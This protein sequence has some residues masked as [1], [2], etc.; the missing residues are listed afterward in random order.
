MDG[1]ASTRQKL[2]LSCLYGVQYFSSSASKARILDV[3]WE[4]LMKDVYSLKSLRN[5]AV[6]GDPW[7]LPE[8]VNDSEQSRVLSKF[9]TGNSGIGNRA[10]ILGLQQAQKYCLLCQEGDSKHWL[11][12]YHVVFKCRRL[13]HVQVEL[14]LQA[15]KIKNRNK[16]SILRRFLGGDG[17]SHVVLM[18]G[19]SRLERL[20][21]AYFTEMRTI[22]INGRKNCY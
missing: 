15:Y 13:R 22:G 8:H 6:R 10:P 5:L 9:R 20:K 1:I 21:D 2:S 4:V 18:E 12:E 3:E 7:E 14:G 17:C 19:G 16:A 11:N